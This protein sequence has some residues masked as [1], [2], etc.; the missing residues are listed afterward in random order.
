VHKLALLIL[1]GTMRTLTLTLTTEDVRSLRM[2][3]YVG[4]AACTSYHTL[5]ANLNWITFIKALRQ[6][7]GVFITTLSHIA[8]AAWPL[9]IIMLLL[10]VSFSIVFVGLQNAGLYYTHDTWL[11][12]SSDTKDSPNV[13][14]NNLGHYIGAY[15]AV[16]VPWWLMSGEFAVFEPVGEISHNWDDI[17]PWVLVSSFCVMATVA[18]LH[19]VVLNLLIA[20]FNAS[21]EQHRNTAHLEFL[22]HKYSIISKH[23]HEYPNLPAPLSLPY[24]IYCIG[25]R[26]WIRSGANHLTRRLKRMTNTQLSK[27]RK[28]SLRR[29]RRGKPGREDNTENSFRSAPEAVK[30]VW[31]S[32]YAIRDGPKPSRLERSASNLG[33]TGVLKIDDGA[34]LRDTM[35][36]GMNAHHRSQWS[37][38]ST[39]HSIALQRH[40]LTTRAAHASNADDS[41]Q[42]SADRRGD[43]HEDSILNIGRGSSM[44][45]ESASLDR[46]RTSMR[47]DGRRSTESSQDRPH[48]VTFSGMMTAQ[49]A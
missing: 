41:V 45:H 30:E 14:E 2:N 37:V 13:Q 12:M 33:A 16:L 8:V 40:Y 38:Q 4:Y 34:I 24:A 42:G 44:P 47:P 1:M 31:N 11:F 32:L 20:I 25:R 9:C 19:I 15:G 6:D 23:M 21:Y 48:E 10:L 28:V 3:L 46:G 29:W 17:G 49:R 7:F 27:L 22:F 35:L 18:T 43:T 39:G 5:V 26:L 36:R